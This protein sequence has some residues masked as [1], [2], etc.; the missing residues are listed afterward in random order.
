MFCNRLLPRQPFPFALEMVPF[1]LLHRLQKHKT[2][3]RH[4]QKTSRGQT[5]VPP[6]A[7][8][9]KNGNGTISKQRLFCH[10]SVLFA[11][12][13]RIDRKRSFRQIPLSRQ[14]SRTPKEGVRVGNFGHFE[15]QPFQNY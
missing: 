4:A 2:P 11:R 1:A 5:Q 7:F 9:A 12:L 10:Y 8:P 6:F 15:P 14:V 13:C 3:S